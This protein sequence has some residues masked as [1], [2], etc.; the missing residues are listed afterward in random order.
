MWM[1]HITMRENVEYC[2]CYLGWLIVYHVTNRSERNYNMQARYHYIA[3]DDCN[4][5]KSTLTVLPWVSRFQCKSHGLTATQAN[6]TGS[7]LCRVN[8]YKCY[9][10]CASDANFVPQRTKNVPWFWK[11]SPNYAYCGK[12]EGCMFMTLNHAYTSCASD[13]G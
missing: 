10:N 2:T 1:G 7:P 5:V 4:I 13:T 12:I 3:L 6:L 11:R 8:N 9:S